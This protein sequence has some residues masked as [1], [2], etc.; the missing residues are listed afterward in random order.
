MGQLP[1]NKSAGIRP[2]YAMIKVGTWGKDVHQINNFYPIAQFSC[3]DNE[4][5]IKV[6]KCILTERHIEGS[7]RVTAQEA[8]EHPEYMS[9]AGEMRWR[10]KPR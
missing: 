7:C 1:Q 4:L 2:S 8:A 5:N 9:D 10:H 3:P 6:G